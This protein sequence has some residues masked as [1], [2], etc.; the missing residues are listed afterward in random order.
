M[1]IR[2]GTTTSIELIIPGMVSEP[3]GLRSNIRQSALLVK[4]SLDYVT[5]RLNALSTGS[6][7]TGR[8]A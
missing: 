7:K 4:I 5:G 6:E 3:I 8:G 2:H 1:E